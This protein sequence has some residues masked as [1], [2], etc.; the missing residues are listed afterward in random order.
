MLLTVLVN[1][2]IAG[3]EVLVGFGQLLHPNQSDLQVRPSGATATP[4]G[5]SQGGVSP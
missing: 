1:Q 4:T 2:T 5:T 3:D